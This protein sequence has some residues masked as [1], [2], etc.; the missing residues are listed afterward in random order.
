MHA[1]GQFH[2][3]TGRQRREIVNV[4]AVPDGR[5]HEAHRFN[6]R[7]VAGRW[8]GRGVCAF[9]YVRQA[10]VDVLAAAGLVAVNG[11]EVLARL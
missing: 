7:R 8:R 11:N 10:D 3:G 6:V 9:D 4:E 1:D 2:E 5:F